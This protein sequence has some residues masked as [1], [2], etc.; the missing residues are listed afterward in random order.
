MEGEM[1]TRIARTNETSQILF[2]EG[3]TPETCAGKCLVLV[4]KPLIA[5]I[6]H[7]CELRKK[8]SREAMK[9]LKEV[10]KETEKEIKKLNKKLNKKLIKIDQKMDYWSK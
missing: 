3:Y 4:R 2:Y 5:G 7:N 1:K 6:I 8:Q 10:R 9:V